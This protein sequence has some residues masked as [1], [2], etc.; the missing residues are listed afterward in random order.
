MPFNCTSSR[1]S[2]QPELCSPVPN[3]AAS[4]H[5][6]ILLL[7]CKSGIWEERAAYRVKVRS[8]RGA[9][10]RALR[11]GSLTCL[12]G[13]A[14]CLVTAERAVNYSVYSWPLAQWSRNNQT[15]HV[16]TGSRRPRVLRNQQ[17]AWLCQLTTE[18]TQS[19]P[20]HTLLV[21]VSRASPG[22]RT[23]IRLDLCVWEFQVYP[24]E[25]CVIQEMSLHRVGQHSRWHHSE[26]LQ[27]HQ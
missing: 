18:V 17:E 21:T 12:A 14:G 9:G 13:D 5:R 10:W 1:S 2:V 8:P 20:H 7:M 22:S 27:G 15:S 24:A 25:E 23:G 26:K 3:L 4:N 16:E 11:D 6:F 19:R